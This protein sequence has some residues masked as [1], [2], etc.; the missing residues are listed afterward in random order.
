M[1]GRDLMAEGWTER[2]DDQ[3]RTATTA[4]AQ[5]G[6]WEAT[7]SLGD[8]QLPAPMAVTMLVSDVAIHGWDLAQ[9]TAQTYRCDDQ[10][11]DVT[12][13]F[14]TEMGDQGRQM[15]IYAAPLPAG[16][17]ASTFERVLALSGRDPQWARLTA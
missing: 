15:G 6:A 8:M 10:V 1:W 5:P 17:D 3:A 9:G 7:V 13:R 14:L 4:W 11:A 16:T 2:F 12:H